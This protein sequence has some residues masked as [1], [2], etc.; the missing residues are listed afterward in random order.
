[1]EDRGFLSRHVDRGVESGL[2]RLLFF[3]GRV[4]GG[5]LLARDLAGGTGLLAVGHGGGEGL[6][7]EEASVF[8]GSR[9]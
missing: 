4:D 6:V 5:E 7:G 1:M 2:G 9:P 8:K 3:G